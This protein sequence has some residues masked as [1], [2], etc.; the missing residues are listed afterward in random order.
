MTRPAALLQS[1]AALGAAATLT[2]AACSDS[3]G[4]GPTAN[5]DVD[6]FLEDVILGDAS[7]PIEVVEYASLS[8]P[9][10]RDFWKQDFPRLKTNYIDTGRV[11]YVLKDFPTA[12]VE[13]AIA[14]TGIARC[15]G[16]DGY[17]DVVDD[18]FTQYHDIMEALRSNT[19]ALPVLIQVGERAGLS[20]EEVRACINHQGVQSYLNDVREEAIEAGVTATPTVFVNGELVSPHD[21]GSLSAKIDALLDPSASQEPTE[22][23]AS[24]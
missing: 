1:F 7:A 18:V 5:V 14:A 6:P 24:E 11:R 20:T 3:G 8:C 22:G 13:L 17:Y 21:Y 16:E 10:C 2:L 12:P 15:A 4:A 9:H 23:E 19:G